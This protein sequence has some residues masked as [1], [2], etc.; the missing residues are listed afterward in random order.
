MYIFALFITLFSC[1]ENNNKL[2][3]K[4]I[5][6]IEYLNRI[7]KPGKAI[8]S[9]SKR[10]TMIMVNNPYGFNGD[11]T[12]SIFINNVVVYSGNFKNETEY[13]IYNNDIVKIRLEILRKDEL[14]ILEDKSIIYWDSLFNYVYCGFFPTNQD[15]D[16]IHFFPQ[17][18]RV[19]Q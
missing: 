2:N 8:N 5:N 12:L 4:K 9:P 14:F 3:S 10:N 6:R 7:D 13:S 16:Q 11:D 18:S 17:Q 15:I 1:N 19:I